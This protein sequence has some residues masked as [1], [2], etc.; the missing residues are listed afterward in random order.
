MADPD[1]VR[2]RVDVGGACR[3]VTGGDPRQISN[4]RKAFEKEYLLS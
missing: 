2:T 3:R 4:T 1:L